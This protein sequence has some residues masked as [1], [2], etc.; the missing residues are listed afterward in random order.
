MTKADK[1]FGAGRIGALAREGPATG[2]KI[3]GARG[4]VSV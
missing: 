1:G 3:P 4:R 2:P